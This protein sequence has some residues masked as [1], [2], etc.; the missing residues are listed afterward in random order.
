MELQHLIGEK[1][2]PEWANEVAKMQAS[3][4]LV[5]E[6]ALQKGPPPQL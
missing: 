6:V 5:E 4:L 1:A 2:G 3:A